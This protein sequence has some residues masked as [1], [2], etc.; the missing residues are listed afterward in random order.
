MIKHILFMFLLSI[1]V[2]ALPK[3]DSKNNIMIVI[4]EYLN[5][6]VK[7]FKNLEITWSSPIIKNSNDTWSQAIK[8][9]IK[10]IMNPITYCFIVS[11][12]KELKVEKMLTLSEFKLFQ[13]ERGIKVDK[14]YSFEGKELSKVKFLSLMYSY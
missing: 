10:D 9:K 1:V 5:A 2:M 12:N 13:K 6:D 4:K 3:I 8:L 11:E 14:I 7:N